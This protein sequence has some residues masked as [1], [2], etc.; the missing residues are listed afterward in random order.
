ML[1]TGSDATDVL[2]VDGSC[3]IRHSQFAI[4]A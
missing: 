1:I 3:S 4:V 2:P